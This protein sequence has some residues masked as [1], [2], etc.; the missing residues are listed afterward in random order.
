VVKPSLQREML[1]KNKGILLLLFLPQLPLELSLTQ[2][3]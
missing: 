1:S 3:H 2:L